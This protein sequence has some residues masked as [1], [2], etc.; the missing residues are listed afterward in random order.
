MWRCICGNVQRSVAQRCS[1]CHRTFLEIK[2]SITSLHLIELAM[3]IARGTKLEQVRAHKA[4][5]GWLADGRSLS[6]I[7][8]FLEN[9]DEPYLK[10][11]VGI[12]RNLNS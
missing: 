7:T 12:L 3:S 9:M 4:I 10:H 2:P 1:G 5:F 11:L 8:R 6:E